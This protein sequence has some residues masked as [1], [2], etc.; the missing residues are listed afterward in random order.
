MPRVAM[1]RVRK[2]LPVLKGCFDDLRVEAPKDSEA[3]SAL[4]AMNPERTDLSQ[5]RNGKV[6]TSRG[7][8]ACC[9]QAFGRFLLAK[10]KLGH[11]IQRGDRGFLPT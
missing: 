11:V 10:L 9:T 8:S 5:N 1:P 6:H 3:A 7:L 4:L 2:D